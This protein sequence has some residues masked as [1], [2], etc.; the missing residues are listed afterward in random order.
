M[1]SAASTHSGAA[2]DEHGNK[3]RRAA[4]LVD[5][6]AKKARLMFGH[7]AGQGGG[8]G[9]GGGEPDG[10]SLSQ[11]LASTQECLKAKIE[12][13]IGEYA[14]LGR[15]TASA[16]RNAANKQQQQQRERQQGRLQERGSAG[17]DEANGGDARPAPDP[18][19]QAVGLT[20]EPGT[21]VETTS[22][23][24]VDEDA[25][26]ELIAEAIDRYVGHELNWDQT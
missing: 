6:N 24:D 9:D 2:H 4:H 1:V 3:H 17:G 12:Y 11:V 22:A 23:M 15:L 8:A 18:L 5:D 26:G 13:K 25:F 21:S 16:A 10:G 19:A 14:G 7:A 20:M